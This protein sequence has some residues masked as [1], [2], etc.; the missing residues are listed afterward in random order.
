MKKTSI[1]SYKNHHYK[2]TLEVNQITQQDNSDNDSITEGRLVHKVKY[3]SIKP[4]T[5]IHKVK[6][7]KD[8]DEVNRPN[9]IK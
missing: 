5:P 3:K 2:I 7:V 1:V 4:K 9:V 8:E 6:K